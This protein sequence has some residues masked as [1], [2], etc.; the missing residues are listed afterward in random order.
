M[1]AMQEKER[2]IELAYRKLGEIRVG[3]R[4]KVKSRG[5]KGNL[6]FCMEGNW[7]GKEVEVCEIR[8]YVD[9][10]GTEHPRPMYDRAGSSF[11]Y[12]GGGFMLDP[13][14]IVRV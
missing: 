5:L 12:F 3:D 2:D 14:N 7:K 13:R 1:T 4:F 9:S 10:Q 6:N 11:G 8:Y